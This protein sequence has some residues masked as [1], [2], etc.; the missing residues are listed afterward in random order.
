MDLQNAL[1][2]SDSQ[3]Q[4]IAATIIAGGRARAYVCP[5]CWEDGLTNNNPAL[6]S[7]YYAYEGELEGNQRHTVEFD[8]GGFDL[9]HN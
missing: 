7:K 8:R 6:T 5:F 1:V 2:I 3:W 4:L 9:L